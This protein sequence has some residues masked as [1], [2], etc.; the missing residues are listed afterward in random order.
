[1][2][3]YELL[4][5][6]SGTDPMEV[7]EKLQRYFRELDGTKD[8]VNHPVVHRSCRKEDDYDLMIVVEIDAEERMG[9]LMDDPLALELQG[10]IAQSIKK[11]KTFDHY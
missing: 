6:V 3:H 1:M 11:R 7:Q 9:E 8:W 5:L 4:R 2:K 10:R